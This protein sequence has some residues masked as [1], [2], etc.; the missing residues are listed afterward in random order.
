MLGG[1]SMG[2][3]GGKACGLVLQIPQQGSHL[4]SSAGKLPAEGCVV[5]SEVITELS[6]PIKIDNL[7]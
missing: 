3:A 1:G 4:L 2:D 5:R 7:L 6:C